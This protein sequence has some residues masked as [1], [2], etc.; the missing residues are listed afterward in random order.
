MSIFIMPVDNSAPCPLL[1]IHF[2]FLCI[3]SVAIAV[4]AVRC[5][6]SMPISIANSSD[7]HLVSADAYIFFISIE[8]K[9]HVL[10]SSIYFAVCYLDLNLFFAHY[11]DFVRLVFDVR[12]NISLQ[13]HS[14][15]Q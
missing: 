13:S 3:F 14:P 2:S 15:T 10:F 11:Y 1:P 5:H 9:S 7:V 6:F 8:F 12:V 4:A